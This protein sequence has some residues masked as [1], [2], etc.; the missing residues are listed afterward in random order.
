MFTPKPT[1][2]CLLVNARR[3]DGRVCPTAPDQ[4]VCGFVSVRGAQKY[5]ELRFLRGDCGSYRVVVTAA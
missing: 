1:I 2:R 4:S 5:G 3:H